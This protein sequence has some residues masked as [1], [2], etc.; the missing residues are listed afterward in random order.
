MVKVFSP[1]NF[2]R[3]IFVSIDQNPVGPLLTNI[4]LLCAFWVCVSIIIRFHRIGVTVFFEKQFKLFH[5]YPPRT[6]GR[7]R[8]ESTSFK[9]LPYSAISSLEYPCSFPIFSYDSNHSSI[10][11]S[12]HPIFTTPG[13]QGYIE[14]H[15]P[16]R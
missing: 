15:V 13:A 12:T 1:T 5:H 2:L 6:L 9:Y 3:I 16:C 7:S 4:T 10:L 11:F 8:I 14:W